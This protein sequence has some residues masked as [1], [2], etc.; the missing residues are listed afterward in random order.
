MMIMMMTMTMMKMMKMM[1]MYPSSLRHVK[2]FESQLQRRNELA[3]DPVS[4]QEHITEEVLY[5]T[6]HHCSR[7]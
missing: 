6:Q 7:N 4:P 5:T 3:H 1:M 2:S